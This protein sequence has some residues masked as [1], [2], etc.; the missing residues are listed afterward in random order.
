LCISPL[1]SERRSRETKREKKKNNSK[2]KTT[3][4][5]RETFLGRAQQE[6]TLFKEEDKEEGEDKEQ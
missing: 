1:C 6:R 5:T 4:N 3:K 2:K